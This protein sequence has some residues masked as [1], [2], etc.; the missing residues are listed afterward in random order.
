MSAPKRRFMSRGLMAISLLSITDLNPVPVSHSPFKL[1]FWF[2]LLS[3]FFASASSTWKPSLLISPF[4]WH[5]VQKTLQAPTCRSLNIVNELQRLL[6]ATW[7]VKQRQMLPK[8]L[9]LLERQGNIRSAQ[10]NRLCSIVKSASTED[11]EQSSL[12][13]EASKQSNPP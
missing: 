10:A 6:S 13:R 7:A 3:C 1:G 2:L 4:V 5:V 8:T 12:R 11:S 9:N